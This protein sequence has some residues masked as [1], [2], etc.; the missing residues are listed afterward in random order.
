[1]HEKPLFAIIVP[2]KN[3]NSFVFECI[4][5]CLKQTIEDF[6]LILLPDKPI[7]MQLLLE[8]FGKKALKKIKCIPTG[9]NIAYGIISAKRNIGIENTKA[10]FLAFIDS[11]AYPQSQWLESALPLLRDEKVGIVGG[12]N[13]APKNIGF[14]ESII[15]KSMNLNVT[16]KGLY[17]LFGNLGKYKQFPVYKEL[18]SSNMLMPR[19]LC[20]QAG[21]FDENYLTGEDMQICAS[22]RKKGKLVLFNKKTAVHHHARS[23]L[24]THFFRIIQYAR[25]KYKMLRQLK[26]FPAFNLLLIAFALYVFSAPF[27]ALPFPFLLPFYAITLALYFFVVCVDCLLNSVKLHELPFCALTVFLTHLAYG[28]GSFQGLFQSRS[29]KK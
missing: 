15:I 14:W 20:L 19:K 13:L 26:E 27:I 28:I 9:S 4:E 29:A 17:A 23:K 2:F 16:Y 24:S 3:L 6:E 10:E 21:K 1:M 25:G 12:P 18:A 5:H 11:D 22:M 7:E 8:R